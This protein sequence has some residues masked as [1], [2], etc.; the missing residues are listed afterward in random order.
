M[1]CPTTSAPASA[2]APR[3]VVS[4]D[5][6]LPYELHPAVE[7]RPEPFGALL[8]S[9]KTRRLSFLKDPL[10]VTLVR[11]LAE[12]STASDACRAAGI[13]EPDRRTM[14]LRALATLASTETIR[15]RT[16]QLPDR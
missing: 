8:Y 9:F 6:D 12:Q 10:L 3:A 1:N 2:A 7:V 15:E 4:F 13:T 16:C 14:F 11:S 5:A